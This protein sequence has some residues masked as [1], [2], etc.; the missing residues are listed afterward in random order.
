MMSAVIFLLIFHALQIN[1]NQDK[2]RFEWIPHPT[3][4]GAG[5]L[6]AKTKDLCFEQYDRKEFRLERCDQ[7]RKGQLFKGF[8]PTGEKFI[9]VPYEE[10]DWCSTLT[11]TNISVSKERMAILPYIQ[12]YQMCHI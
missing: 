10:K 8:D 9:L 2:F 1:N 4:E 12:Y 3:R 5:Q 7:D 6:K 11:V